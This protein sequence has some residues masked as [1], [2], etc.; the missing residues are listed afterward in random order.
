MNNKAGSAAGKVAVSVL[1][2]LASLAGAGPA[3]AAL[4]LDY[5]LGSGNPQALIYYNPSQDLYLHG[6]NIAVTQISGSETA[7]NAGSAGA[8][9]VSGGTLNFVTGALS[10]EAVNTLNFAG[11]GYLSV[12]GGLSALPLAGM[13]TLLSGT[14]TSATLTTLPLSGELQFDIFGATLSA[15]DNPLIYSYFNIP[16]GS[17]AAQG[18]SLSFLASGMGSAGFSSSGLYG[19]TIVDVPTSTPIPAAA[20]LFGSGLLGLAGIRRKA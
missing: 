8:L 16:A 11:G 1:V 13:S 19:G 9:N 7:L 20:W 5:A 3:R 18:M 12:T 17:G 15:V 14:F 10:S 6:S 2:A 4:S